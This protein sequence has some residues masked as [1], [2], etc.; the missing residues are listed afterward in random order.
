MNIIIVGM[1][2]GLQFGGGILIKEVNSAKIDKQ[3][4]FLSI[5]MINLI[6][7]IIEDTLLM[8]SC[9]RTFFRSYFCKNCL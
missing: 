7:A 3:S 6:H 8:L 4:V 9:W 5:L 1:T 2:I